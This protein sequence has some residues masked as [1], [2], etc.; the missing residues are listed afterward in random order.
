MKEDKTHLAVVQLEFDLFDQSIHRLEGGQAVAVESDRHFG[1]RSVGRVELSRCLSHTLIQHTNN[2][3][4][5]ANSGSHFGGS[6]PI[7]QH[8]EPFCG[9]RS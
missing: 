6:K 7:Y 1:V 3:E 9:N 8:L 2:V 5:E 4:R